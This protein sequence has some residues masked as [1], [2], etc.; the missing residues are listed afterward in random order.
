[1]SQDVAPYGIVGG[2]PAKL[3]KYR[4]DENTRGKLLQSEWWKMEAEQLKK[5]LP[6]FNNPESFLAQL[7]K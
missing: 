5:M 2:V 1:M 3:I 6:F 4:F 7:G